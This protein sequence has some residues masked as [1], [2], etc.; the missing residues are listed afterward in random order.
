M[1]AVE[2]FIGKTDNEEALADA[3]ATLKAIQI[4]S[5]EAAEVTDAE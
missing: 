3:I 2:D 5:K 1:K 4:P